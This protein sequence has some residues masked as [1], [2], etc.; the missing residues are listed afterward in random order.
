MNHMI[1]LGNDS[2]GGFHDSAGGFI[3]L[4]TMS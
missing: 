4:Q 3:Y 1:F 2:V